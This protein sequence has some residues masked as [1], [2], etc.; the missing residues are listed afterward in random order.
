MNKRQKKK[1]IKKKVYFSFYKPALS[2][3]P[4]KYSNCSNYKKLRAYFHCYIC[5]DKQL[6]KVARYRQQFLRRNI[7][8][9]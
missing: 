7:S 4:S 8:K 9:L 1:S 6:R 5:H 3:L 2:L